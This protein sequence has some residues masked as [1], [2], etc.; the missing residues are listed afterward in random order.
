MRDRFESAV[1]SFRRNYN[2]GAL[3]DVEVERGRIHVA[4]D[5]IVH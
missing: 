1:G 3:V 2:L 5:N 4:W